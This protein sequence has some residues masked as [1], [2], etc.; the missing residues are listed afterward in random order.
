MCS[1]FGGTM[2][3]KYIIASVLGLAAVP[4]LAIYLCCAGSSNKESAAPNILGGSWSFGVMGDTQWTTPNTPSTGYD[5]NGKSPN[6]VAV[7]WI[8]Q[9]NQEFIAKK[10]KFVIQVGDLTDVPTREALM[11]TSKYRQDLYNA[12]IGFFALRGNHENY[13]A[14]STYGGRFVIDAD[15]TRNEQAKEFARV[16]PQTANGVMN[17]LPADVLALQTSAGASAKTGSTFTIGSNFSSPS[18][19]NHDWSGLSYSFN[20]E[21]A[22]FVM[23][24]Q[25]AP[26]T[27]DIGNDATN[28]SLQQPWISSVL[29][30]RASANH[31][32]V[33][34]HKGL[35]HENHTDVINGAPPSA[36]ADI[37]DAFTR[38]LSSAGVKYFHSGHDHMHCRS[39]YTTTDGNLDTSVNQIVAAS[40]SAKYYTPLQNLPDASNSPKSQTILSQELYTTG[41][42]I[43]TV[44]GNNVTVD[45][46]SSGRITGQDR[47][48]GN[49]ASAPDINDT[50]TATFTKKDSWGYSLTGKRFIIA[51]SGAYTAVQD[52]AAR[53]LGGSNDSF[54]T[55]W[56]GREYSREVTT[57]WS[58]K[59]TG[60]YTDIFT[61]WGM[62]ALGQQSTDPYCLSI[63]YD[64]SQIND[65]R[66]KSGNIGIAA[67]GADTWV[68]AVSQ[69]TG[70]AKNFVVGPYDPS[71]HALGTWGV[72]T[73]AR[74]FWA[75]VN[76]NADFAV[77]P[78]I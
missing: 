26:K 75:V 9:M 57:G 42:Y 59:T 45:Y 65:G 62:T 4:A 28:L 13:G 3:K 44:N 21:N 58:P 53:I 32:F 40:C 52:G 47:S 37:R 73:A 17:N 51:P 19:P 70:G 48:P 61:I 10:V 76:Y 72:D 66:A 36:N 31:A 67:R 24:D 34:S 50:P 49:Y 74:S 16:F 55:D 2:S 5:D 11:T 56:N 78:G 43:Y 15:Y 63:A 64:S 35:I 12:G 23:L 14:Q 8:K 77:A 68:N 30:G 54:G 71:K 69:N 41:Y 39:I 46:Y 25:F 7:A 33:F 29:S 60:L 22:T 1:F 38:S 18:L 20:Y 6:T 27:G